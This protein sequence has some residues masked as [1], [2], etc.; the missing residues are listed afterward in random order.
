MSVLQAYDTEHDLY[1]MQL[2]RS[3]AYQMMG[4]A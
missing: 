3:Y 1:F 4:T 2:G